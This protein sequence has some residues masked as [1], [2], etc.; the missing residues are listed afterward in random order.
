MLIFTIMIFLFPIL[1]DFFYRC[2]Y[3]ENCSTSIYY[4]QKKQVYDNY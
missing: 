4:K 1:L 2:K 3:V